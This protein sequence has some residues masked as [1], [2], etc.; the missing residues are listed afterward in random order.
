VNPWWSKFRKSSTF[1]NIFY[2][3]PLNLGLKK[4]KIFLVLFSLVFLFG[5]K[6]KSSDCEILLKKLIKCEIKKSGK[7]KQNISKDHFLKLCK[8]NK[9]NPQLKIFLECAKLDDCNSIS[10]C[11]LEKNRKLKRKRR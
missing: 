11:L 9:D 1:F 2:L 8:H 3:L 7:R 10:Q 5:C 6:K 4:M